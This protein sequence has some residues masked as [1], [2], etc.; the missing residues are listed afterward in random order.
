ME[1][2][3]GLFDRLTLR[4]GSAFMDRWA[5]LS[6]AAVKEDW[7]RKL[8]SYAQRPEVIEHALSLLDPA[9]PPTAAAFRELCASAPAPA[10]RAQ[11]QVKQSQRAAEIRRKYL[12]PV[13]PRVGRE[14]AWA[15]EMVQRARAGERVPGYSLRLA[16]DALNRPGAS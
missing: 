9:G 4:Y 12:R 2:I 10:F 15:A 7:A 6:L 16:L 13:A 8:A 11:P 14:R 3:E 1:F 5:G